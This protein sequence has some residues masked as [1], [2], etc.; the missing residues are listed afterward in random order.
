M[1]TDIKET[2]KHDL[3]WILLKLAKI[4][5]SQNLLAVLLDLTLS[6]SVH[7][8]LTP[9]NCVPMLFYLLGLLDTAKIVV[10]DIPVIYFS[11]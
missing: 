5:V 9:L 10:I 7:Q 8:L 2:I 6:L 4:L 11:S 1:H 3:L